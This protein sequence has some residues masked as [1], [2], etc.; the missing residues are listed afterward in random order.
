MTVAPIDLFSCFLHLRQGGEIEAAPRALDDERDG[1][2][3]TAF[4]AKTD[5]DVHADHWE[6]HPEAEEVVSCLIGKLRL[7]LRPEEPGLQEEVIRLT[8]GTA[9]IIP[10]G[11]WHR[12]E[13]DTPSSIMALTLPRG[14]RLEKRTA[15][16]PRGPEP[17]AVHRAALR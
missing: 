5:A 16:R 7:Y 11:R 1:W 8:A 6:V 17:T 9:A 13:L 2:R 3:L 14:S 12:M 10:R 4:H 15:G